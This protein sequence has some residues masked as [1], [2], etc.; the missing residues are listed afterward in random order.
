MKVRTISIF[1]VLLS[2]IFAVQA[3]SQNGFQTG[4]IVSVDKRAVESSS[5]HTDSPSHVQHDTYDIGIQVNGK[6][7]NCVY[8]SHPDIDPSWAVGKDV[9]VR[10]SG[11]KAIYVRRSSGH[12]EKLSITKTQP[13]G[14]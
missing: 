4:K 7:Y 3:F 8:H 12:Q 13:G 5:R 10:L 1:A 2:L 11:S 14:E 9:Q 6:V